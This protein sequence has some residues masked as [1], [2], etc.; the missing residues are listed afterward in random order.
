MKSILPVLF[1][2][3]SVIFAQSSATVTGSVKVTLKEKPDTVYA[4][5]YKYGAEIGES[6]IELLKVTSAKFSFN[7]KPG[8][9]SLGIWAFGTDR[10][11]R[12]IIV[13]NP[14][15]PVKLEAELGRQGIDSETGSVIVT[16]D[17]CG[18]NPMASIPLSKKENVW[19]LENDSIIPDGTNYKFVVNSVMYPNHSAKNYSLSPEW[20]TMN[21][22]KGKEKI[23]FNPELYKA[24]GTT[25]IKFTGTPFTDN[26]AS[27]KKES[28]NL[29]YELIQTISTIPRGD[30][31][32]VAK[33]YHYFKCKTDSL[34]NKYGLEAEQLFL[35]PYFDNIFFLSPISHHYMQGFKYNDSLA[36][37]AFH[38]RPEI[39]SIY[40]EI[41]ENY[42]KIDPKALTF[43]ANIYFYTARLKHFIQLNPGFGKKHNVN[44]EYYDNFLDKF[45]DIAENP[46]DTESLLTSLISLYSDSFSSSKEK[47]Q[48]YADILFTRFPA[49]PNRDYINQKLKSFEQTPG[50]AIPD[51]NLELTN[52]TQ[53]ALKNY[54]GKFLFLEFWGISCPPCRM[55]VPHINELYKNT[56]RDTLEILGMNQ[57]DSFENIAEF[58][59]NFGIEYP[60]AKANNEIVTAF[61]V[62]G[63]PASFL[64]DPDGKL[65]VRDLRGEDLTK[66]VK[67]YISSYK[68]TSGKTE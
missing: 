59:K 39:L 37:K 43:D 19:V 29:F 27:A 24:D 8:N 18:W 31:S 17:F 35:R 51:F 61:S 9:Y 13:T 47:A 53:T 5:L 1:F 38:A 34:S 45:I 48:K 49:T 16:G 2:L 6:P 14:D 21:S 66:K 3:S 60:T 46:D 55:E 32:N 57:S 12:K 23:V 33:K 28:E 52:D 26:F 50:W 42:H 10:I 25:A 67:E 58:Q 44:S 62:T 7:A 40:E 68:S 4:G 41:N 22:I 56:S 36:S 30:T 11:E 54:H 15:T 65:I 64:F 63:I 20:S